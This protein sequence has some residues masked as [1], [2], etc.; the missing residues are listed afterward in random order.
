MLANCETRNRASDA[1]EALFLLFCIFNAWHLCHCGP[2]IPQWTFSLPNMEV[3]GLC[4][5]KTSFPTI[6][7]VEIQWYQFLL[8]WHTPESAS[9]L[10][11]WSRSETY[12]TSLY[13]YR[14]VV[15]LPYH[16]F[17]FTKIKKISFC[18]LLVKVGCNYTFRYGK[19]FPHPLTFPLKFC[20][21]DE[22]LCLAR[23]MTQSDLV[24]CAFLH[25][26]VIDS[27]VGEVVL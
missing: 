12:P 18:L 14:V 3:Q 21:F 27:A 7:R 16:F 4:E 11:P 8:F 25:V 9:P 13:C 19:P 20:A 10:V 2:P 6:L 22:S 23:Q 15:F 1:Y 26:Y 24:N 5:D 17:P